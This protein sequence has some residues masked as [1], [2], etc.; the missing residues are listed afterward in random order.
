MMEYPPVNC[1][2]SLFEFPLPILSELLQTPIVENL[3][4]PKDE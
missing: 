3:E 4:K 1:I 2:G